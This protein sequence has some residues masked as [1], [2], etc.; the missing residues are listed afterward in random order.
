MS[1]F[2]S[3]LAD[4]YTTWIPLE[5]QFYRHHH[6]G[7]F[8]FNSIPEFREWP[9]FQHLH[10]AHAKNGG[11]IAML[12]KDN[13][14]TLGATLPRNKLF[15][16]CSNGRHYETIDLDR[17]ISGLANERANSMKHWVGMAFN[18]DEDLVLLNAEGRLYIVDIVLK[19]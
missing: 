12:P 2:Y 1:R 19:E 6:I 10:L 13:V 18:S 8:D 9:E 15:I 5:E 11:P 14:V 17:I 7:D 4:L 3:R 16:F